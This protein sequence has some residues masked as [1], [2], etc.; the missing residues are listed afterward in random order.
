MGRRIRQPSPAAQLAEAHLGRRQQPMGLRTLD[1]ATRAIAAH[2]HRTGTELPQLLTAIVHGDRIDL[3]LAAPIPRG[4]R[5]FRGRGQPMATPRAGRRPVALDPGL[6]DAVRPYPALVTL[7]VTA[8]GGQVV[9]D[10]E[11]LR[12]ISVEAAA[13]EPAEAVLSAIAV[14][15]SCSPW[16]E[17]LEV[18][19]IGACER[20]PDALGRHNVTRADELGPVLDRLSQ[21]AAAQRTH[22]AGTSVAAKRIDPDLADPWVPTIVVVNASA[23]GRRAAAPPKPGALRAAGEHRRGRGESDGR[24]LSGGAVRGRGGPRRPDRAV[25]PRAWHRSC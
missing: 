18:V 16:A 10:L 4:T 14:E 3:E 23:V 13:G 2:C 8:D 7:G 15:L 6:R 11:Q 20:L 5:R 24:A 21:R 22:L 25:R 12:L 17:E 9:A 1:L 19:V